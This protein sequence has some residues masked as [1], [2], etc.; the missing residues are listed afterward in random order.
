MSNPYDTAVIVNVRRGAKGTFREKFIYAEL[1]DKSNNEILIS[2]S[3]D[4]VVQCL[5]ERKTKVD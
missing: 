1:R 5:L 3:L 4:Y 2:G